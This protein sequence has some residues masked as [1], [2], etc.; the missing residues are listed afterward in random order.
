MG[1]ATLLAGAAV[2]FGVARWLGLPAVPL[3]M[4]AG[5]ALS[6]LGFVPS[7]LLEDA[8]VLGLTFL[9]FVAGLELDPRRVGAQRPAALRVGVAQFVLLGAVGLLAALGL[10]FDAT[11]ALYLALALAASSTLVVV[12][13]LQ[14]R[15]Q[16]FEPFGRLVLGVLLLQ[17]LLVILLIP[18]LPRLPRGVGAV[19]LGVAAAVALVGLAYVCLRWFMPFVVIRLGLDD[20]SVLLVVLAFLFLFVG[21]AEGLHLPFVAGAFL[22]GVAL[23]AF[24]VSGL[25]RAQLHSLS[26]FFVAVFF[27]ALGG[28]LVFPTA[29]ELVQALVLAFLVVVLTPPLVSVLGER[30]G[31][32]ARSAIEGGLLL[33]QTSEFSLVVGLQGLVATQIVPGAFRVIALVTVVTMLLTPLVATDEMARRLMRFHPQRRRQIAGDEEPPQGHVLLL[34]CGENGMAVLEELIVLGHRVFVVDDDPGV[35]AQLRQAE[36]PALRGDGADRGVLERAGARHARMIISTLRRPADSVP[37][38]ELA[39][40]VPTL[41]RVFDDAAAAMIRRHGATPILVSEAAAEEF[42]EWYRA[43]EATGALRATGADAAAVEAVQ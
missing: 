34:G 18:V 21:S 2:A 36:I 16:L 10:G 8:V 42:M 41:V 38:L 19:V 14:V 20:E 3:L 33:A 6:V 12:R 30:A 9:V 43:A 31:M 25:V 40:G 4:L 7:Q 5:A 1:I 15:Q 39:R 32:S 37:V 24:P 27:T 26:D 11:T 28:F 29:V 13:L 35:I 23:S 22:A 17:D